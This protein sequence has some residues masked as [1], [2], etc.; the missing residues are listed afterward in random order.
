MWP[1]RTSHDMET[2]K[3]VF[4]GLAMLVGIAWPAVFVVVLLDRL[5][6]RSVPRFFGGGRHHFPK[7]PPLPWWHH[8]IRLPLYSVVIL[9]LALGCI[10]FL[11]PMFV[12]E[13]PAR[14]RARFTGRAR[15]AS[16][17]DVV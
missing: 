3:D 17:E 14:L 16:H 11:A 8:L 9:V 6:G 10:L 13:L 12:V 5:R 15:G 4:I 1:L 2:P 7:L